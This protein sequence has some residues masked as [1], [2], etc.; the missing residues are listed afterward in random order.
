MK[1]LFTGGGTMGPV[2]PLLAI[3]ESWKK[4]D[5]NVK[6]VWVGTKRGPERSVIEDE[7]IPFLYIPIARL[8]RYFS[9]EWLLLPFNFLRALILSWFILRRVKPDLIASA[10]GFTGVPIIFMAWL[11]RIPVWVHQQDVTPLLANRLV[12]PWVKLITV[13]WEKTL[14]SFPKNKTVWI[15][16]PVRE[17]ILLGKKDRAYEIFNLDLSLPTVLVFG[18]GGGSTWLNH[19]FEEI[20]AWLETQANIIHVTGRG[21]IKRKLKYLGVR[22]HAYEFLT[23]EMAHAL[24]A[25][26]I[27]VGRA[28]MGTI[29]ELA[30]LHKPSVLIPL[31]NSPQE[32]NVELLKKIQ[33]A[34]ILQQSTTTTGDLKKAIQDLLFDKSKQKEMA[35]NLSQLLPTKINNDLVI[36]VKKRCLKNKK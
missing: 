3:S 16:N 22:Y 36:L 8:T 9:G 15:G 5:L 32:K 26:D 6:F 1:I 12:V 35:N 24:A 7:G 34:T 25:S 4:K 20:G 23:F 29:S 19:M 28:G 13:A 31:P 2:T 17:T 18:G 27:V 30:A 33:A 11:R 14:T 21:K 10:G